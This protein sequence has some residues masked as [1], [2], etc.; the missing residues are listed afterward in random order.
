[1]NVAIVCLHSESDSVTQNYPKHCIE[2]KLFMYCSLTF[3]EYLVSAD[4][5][6]F[7][8]QSDQTNLFPAS[9][10]AHQLRL[11]ACP[12]ALMMP[13]IS[14]LLLNSKAKWK[15][16]TSWG[17]EMFWLTLST[18]EAFQGSA[19]DVFICHMQRDKK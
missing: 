4:K 12:P 13:W 17:F 18:Q 7:H 9:V 10:P 2:I 3:A 19:T 8:V 16:L 14:M 15:V 11:T 1:M 5:Q 6:C